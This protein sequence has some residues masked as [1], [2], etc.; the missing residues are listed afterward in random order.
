MTI[1]TTGCLSIDLTPTDGIRQCTDRGFGNTMTIPSGVVCY[2]RM[3]AGSEADYLCDDG[4]HQNGAVRRVCQS[5]GV[6]NGRIPQ[7][8]P[9]RRGQDGMTNVSIHYCQGH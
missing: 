8:L 2:N 1:F 4:F 7:C 3:T 6:W 5:N 9:D